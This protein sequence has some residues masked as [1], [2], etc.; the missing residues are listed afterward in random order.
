MNIKD[1]SPPEVKIESES[2]CSNRR[3]NFVELR[4]RVPAWRIP[5]EES[6]EDSHVA[7]AQVGIKSAVDKE[8][9][10]GSL[11]R[12]ILSHLP[13]ENRQKL[14]YHALKLLARAKCEPRGTPVSSAEF[15][16]EELKR[17]I[18]SLLRIDPIQTEHRKLSKCE[19]T[20]IE[21]SPNRSS[22]PDQRNA[23]YQKLVKSSREHSSV[24]IL[25]GFLLGALVLSMISKNNNN[26]RDPLHG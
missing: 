9:S 20:L 10:T 21:I 16:D 14:E 6:D 8:D 15:D 24:A 5:K 22:D 17:R 3:S 7:T 12:D 25:I 11:L 19:N 4:G 13:A 23:V 1:T 18:T 2:S 26:K